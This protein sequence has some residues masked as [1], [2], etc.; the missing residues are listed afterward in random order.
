MKKSEIYYSAMLC[1]L[2]SR[3]GNDRKLE[4]LERLIED[5]STALWSEKHE[6]KHE[7]NAK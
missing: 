4:I 6:E 2:D 3:L 7:E 5:R 1:V